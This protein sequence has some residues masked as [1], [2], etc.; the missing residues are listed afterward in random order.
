MEKVSVKFKALH[1]KRFYGIVFHLWK[2]VLWYSV[3]NT[4]NMLLV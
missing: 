2:K 3:S 1:T 4:Q